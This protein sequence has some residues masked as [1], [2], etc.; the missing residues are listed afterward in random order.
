MENNINLTKTTH[1]ARSSLI[2]GL[3]IHFDSIL[4]FKNNSFSTSYFL[5]VIAIEEIGKA[6]FLDHFI[7]TSVIDGRMDR[8]TEE[9]WLKSIF[10]HKSKQKYFSRFL[11]SPNPTNKLMKELLDG[12]MEI[13]KQNSIYVGPKREGKNILFDEKTNIPQN[14]SSTKVKKL[15]T[16]TNSNLLEFCLM[17]ITDTG[18]FDSLILSRVFNRQLYNKLSNKWKIIDKETKK[19]LIH[20]K[21]FINA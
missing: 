18:G 5:A 7:D 9:D 17:Q 12:A 4:L 10:D 2:N 15:I 19:R 13:N 6:F 14:I 11:D 3:N 1:L 21:T 16:L 8:K 20:L